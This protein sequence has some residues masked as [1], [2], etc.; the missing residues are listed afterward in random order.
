MEEILELQLMEN[1]KFEPVLM[2]MSSQSNSCFL[3]NTAK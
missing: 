3:C 1:E 2:G